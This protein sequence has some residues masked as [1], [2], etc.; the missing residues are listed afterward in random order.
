MLKE[1][2]IHA[3]NE[4]KVFSKTR[5][6]CRGVVVKDCRM[7]VSHEVKTDYYL[8]PGGGLEKNETPEE[9]CAREVCE[10]TGYVVKPKSHFLTINEYYKDCKFT[11]HYFVCDIIGESEQCLTAAE[12]QRGLVAEWISTKKVLEIYSKYDD[13]AATNEEKRCSYLRE[14]TALQEYFNLFL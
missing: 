4:N 6:G 9:C 13:F 2:D 14:Y 1:I 7:L 3:A 10:E 8:I 5:V 11:S 12:A